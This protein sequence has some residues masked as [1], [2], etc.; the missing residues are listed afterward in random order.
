VNISMEKKFKYLLVA[1]LFITMLPACSMKEAVRNVSMELMQVR[2]RDFSN[3]GFTAVVYMQVNNENGFDV[4]ISDFDYHALV[5]DRE[6]ASG[7]L[8]KEIVIPSHGSTVAEIPVHADFSG[9]DNGALERMLRGRQDYRL[10]G[11]ALFKAWFG[12]YRYSFDTSGRKL[13]KKALEK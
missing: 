10:T 4:T 11:T 9:L 6:L 2:V 8:E 3:S 12:S 5:S 13:Y 1:A 7:K